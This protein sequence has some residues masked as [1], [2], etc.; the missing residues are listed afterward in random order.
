MNRIR[1]REVRVLSPFGGGL[2]D[3]S[4]APED[5]I[6]IVFWT[7]DAR[8]IAPFLDEL[9][10]R[11]LDFTFL[12]TVNNYPAFL[13]PGV[14]HLSETVRVLDL[15]A[16]RFPSS[17]LRWRYDTIVL[18]ETLDASWHA[19]NFADLC[20]VLSPYT[21]E[22]IFSFCDY[23]KK[24]LRN[25]E[26]SVPNYRIPDENQSV[27]IVS[28]IAQIAQELG[29]ELKSC[30]HDFLVSESVKKARCI[31]RDTLAKIVT[32]PER[33]KAVEKLKKA[34]SRRQCGCYASRDIG[35]YDTCGHGCVYCYANSDPVRASRNLA[36][37]NPGKV[38]L[39]P[40]LAEVSS[41]CGNR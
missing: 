28:E 12:Y 26:R 23:Y 10:D 19:A 18:T 20:R 38:C 6:G 27:D 36:L 33:L 2:F 17:V 1:A 16:H 4:L 13:E 3:V 7:K 11:G 35:A 29:V 15:L 39:D 32:T 14:P 30:S 5:V 9:Q 22:C 41:Q 21:S 8:P 24:T 31:D 34:P 37:A 25:M 40:R